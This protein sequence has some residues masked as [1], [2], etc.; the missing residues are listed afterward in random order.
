MARRFPLED[1]PLAL[2]RSLAELSPRVL[3]EPGFARPAVTVKDYLREHRLPWDPATGHWGG[4]HGAWRHTVFAG[5]VPYRTLL[6]RAGLEFGPAPAEEGPGPASSLT[7]LFALRVEQD[8]AADPTSLEFSRACWAALARS[9]FGRAVTADFDADG[10]RWRAAM[11]TVLRSR[12]VRLLPEPNAEEEADGAGRPS[13][14]AAS[15]GA[16]TPEDAG[17]PDAAGEPGTTSPPYGVP[18]PSGA[19]HLLDHGD[20]LAMIEETHRV[21]EAG[22]LRS[23]RLLRSPVRVLSLLQDEDRAGVPALPLIDHPSAAPLVEAAGATRFRQAA[24][25]LLGIGAA[26]PREEAASPLLMYSAVAP[27]ELPLGVVGAAGAAVA[28]QFSVNRALARLSEGAGLW[29]VPA[30]LSRGLDAGRAREMLLSALIARRG[31]ALA[32]LP[33]PAEAFGPE[34]ADPSGSRRVHPL[35][36]DLAGCGVLRAR[37]LEDLPGGAGGLGIRVGILPGM[38]ECGLYPGLV[39]GEGYDA[40]E[41]LDVVLGAL[42]EPAAAGPTPAEYGEWDRLADRVLAAH[43]RVETLLA[44]RQRYHEAVPMLMRAQHQISRTARQ[45]SGVRGTEQSLEGSLREAE[46]EHRSAWERAHSLSD[47]IAEHLSASPGVVRRSV[48]LGRTVPPWRHRLEELRTRRDEAERAEEAARQRRDALQRELDRVRADAAVL[49]EELREA[50][51]TVRGLQEELE[52]YPHPAHA[53]DQDWLAGDWQEDTASSP[54]LDAEVQDARVEA[55]RSAALLHGLA[56]R[57]GAAE[58]REGLLLARDLLR[59]APEGTAGTTP[60]GTAGAAPGGT[61]EIAPGGMEG[62]APG[63]TAGTAE[64]GPGADAAA[65]AWQ[66]LLAVF[67]DVEVAV[68]LLPRLCAPLGPHRLDWVL[69]SDADRTGPGVAYAALRHAR[70]AVLLPAAEE[71]GRPAA[72]M[73]EGPGAEGAER[74]PADGGPSPDPAAPF[75]A[76][77][78]R[79]P[80]RVRHHSPTRQAQRRL[81]QT[82][83]CSADWAPAWADALSLARRQSDEPDEDPR[84]RRPE[85]G[86]DGA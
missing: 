14:T 86:V 71:R 72:E 44:A 19:T 81:A 2:W 67:P 63:R 60:G 39:P 17:A 57:F 20:L 3:P 41:A 32:E 45:L 29:A 82:E 79:A 64:T 68:E 6:V 62:A 80:R 7:P 1:D 9:G 24:A 16:G 40:V 51:E 77:R 28:T 84:R 18:G 12:G 21:F 52:A 76:E 56:G 55:Y 31:R 73:E 23:E 30:S 47:A 35:H 49:R 59:A 5:L 48:T 11:V 43:E 42:P 4:A 46:A 27:R 37:P 85:A 75:E 15:D 36:P 33:D 50:A 10:R 34:P 25:G 8:G 83:G 22:A 53:V 69:L 54:W 78:P 58:V 13:G 26:E 70:R 74:S 66:V 65:A 38:E 61:E